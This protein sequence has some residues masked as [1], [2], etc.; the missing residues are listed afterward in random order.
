[1]SASQ[2]ST[3]PDQQSFLMTGAEYRR[4]L[5]DGRKVIN[6]AGEVIEDVAADP[7]FGA[8]IDLISQ[9]YDAQHAE[10]TRDL[11]TY[12]DDEV[13]GRVSR[14]WQVPRTREDLA[15]RREMARFT[16]Y[17]M[18]GSFGRPPDY[19]PLVPIGYLSIADELEALD[20]AGLANVHKFV[21]WGKEHNALSADVIADVQS[22]R[23]IPISQKPGRLRAVKHTSDGVV[24]YGAKPCV[25]VGV[26]GHVG[27][28]VTALTPG[29]DLDAAIFCWIPFNSEG[30]TFVSR[31]SVAR[32][33]SA[34]DHP[35]D[36][37]GE[38]ADT[39]MLFDNVFVPHEN[40]FS[41]GR[42]EMLPIYYKKGGLGLW[43]V[44]TRLSF[45]AEIFAGTGQ[46]ISEVLGTTNIAQV[47][48]SISEL[49]S[50]A[51]TL[52]AFV[53]AAEDNATLRNGV[54]VPDE[55]FVTAGRL[56]SI[57][58]YPRVLQIL[59]DMSGQGLISRFN[60]A[61]FEHEDVRQLMEEFLPGTGVS[62][63]AKNRL[64]NFVWDLTCGSNA[65]RVALFENVN[66]TP[67]SA[68]RSRIYNSDFR[69]PWR[70][71]VA[72]FLDIK[73]EAG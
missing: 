68:I 54:I 53:L 9:Y 56:H 38:E 16:T 13:G 22:D 4:S 66:S 44:L 57:A 6:G 50:Y 26:Q 31:E 5:M 12:V 67:P 24:L 49:S 34:E 58:E 39:M 21:R 20:P 17:H 23:R 65:M 14:A 35:L 42:Q 51:T 46:L 47:R 30:L 52:K 15:H 45:K 28:I 18:M 2:A 27:T 32:Q 11:L 29:A 71:S 33:G 40:F 36:S 61:A 3:A 8:G 73:V 10:E 48:D 37:R 55:R 69:Q 19:G 59:R 43:H 72:D 63:A 25:S 1:M 60:T 41:F 62:A 70:N 64:F 7:S